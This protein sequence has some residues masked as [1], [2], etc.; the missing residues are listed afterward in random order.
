MHTLVWILAILGSLIGAAVL[1]FGVL[2]AQGAPQE[3]AA[4]AIA[5]AWAILPYVGARAVDELQKRP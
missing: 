4:A 2:F 1:L 3:G 5:C